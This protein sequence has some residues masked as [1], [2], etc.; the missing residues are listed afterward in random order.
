MGLMKDADFWQCTLRDVWQCRP[1]P[2]QD[3]TDKA[4]LGA[5]AVAC[6][7]LGRLVSD[8]DFRKDLEDIAAQGKQLL[9]NRRLT[10]SV[11]EFV[12]AERMILSAKDF[13]DN[14]IGAILGEIDLLASGTR[15]TRDNFDALELKFHRLR[16]LACTHKDPPVPPQNPV[17][18]TIVDVSALS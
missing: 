13:N 17:D 4:A 2:G 1:L 11:E 18:R 16:T 9:H 3:R 8:P 15:I 7:S 12:E 10:L 6:E 5:L 14:E